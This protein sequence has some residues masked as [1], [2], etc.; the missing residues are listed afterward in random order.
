MTQAQ[1]DKFLINL[2]SAFSGL[3]K[4]PFPTIAVV[5]GPALEGGLEMALCR[6]LRVVG[7]SPVPVIC[8]SGCAYLTNPGFA[9]TK[10]ALTEMELGIVP[11]AG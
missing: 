3:E 7:S 5:D 8:T 6:D 11:G 9:I 4:L 10:I 1:I 2:R